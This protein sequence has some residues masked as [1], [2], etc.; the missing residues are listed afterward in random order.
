MRHLLRQPAFQ[1]N[2]IINHGEILLLVAD[3]LVRRLIDRWQRVIRVERII[4]QAGYLQIAENYLPG[5]TAQGNIAVREQPF[6]VCLNTIGLRR[7]GVAHYRRIVDSHLD[8][9]SPDGDGKLKPLPVFY[10]RTVE[11][12]HRRET[13]A[14]PRPVDSAVTEKDFVAARPVGMEEQGGFRVGLG[15][16]FSG[17]NEIGIIFSCQPG[18]AAFHGQFLAG[19]GAG[20]FA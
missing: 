18:R 13:S 9:L 8:I 15:A 3:D 17:Q 5:R 11:V 20:I 14:L 4:F 12:A 6:G 19:E 1:M 2:V 16:S 7:L 10:L